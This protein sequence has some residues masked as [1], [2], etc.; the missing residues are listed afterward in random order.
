MP[1]HSLAIEGQYPP[2][3]IS[4]N[5]FDCGVGGTTRTTVAGIADRVVVMPFVPSQ[6]IAVDRA[7]ID[8]TTAVAAAEARMVIYDSDGAGGVPSTRLY[9]SA[10][11]DCST[12][13]IKEVTLAFTFLA[14]ELYWVGVHNSSTATLRAVGIAD[15]RP[16][17][18]IGTSS[19]AVYTAYRV[20]S[21]FGTDSPDPFGTPILL[22]ANVPQVKFR[23]V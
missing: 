9:D 3:Y 18:V 14:G 22:N 23:V 21:A 12:T 8:V 2:F 6:D 11:Q 10:E 7:A 5:Y 19:G 17:G 13:G 20:G 15:C 1:R 4:G 16:I